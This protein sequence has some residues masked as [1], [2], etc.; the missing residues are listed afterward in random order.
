[1]QMNEEE[2][3]KLTLDDIFTKTEMVN[4]VKAISPLVEKRLIDEARKKGALQ[5]LKRFIKWAL[6]ESEDWNWSLDEQP[7]KDYLEKR[8]KELE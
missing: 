6:E 5:E 3:N 8:L 7:V 2:W 4:L 1:M